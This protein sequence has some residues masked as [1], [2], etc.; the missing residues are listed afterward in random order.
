MPSQA[1][2]FLRSNET[3]SK[4]ADPFQ[5]Y[6]NQIYPKTVREVFEWA[7]WLWMRHGIYSQ[8]IKRSVRYFLNSI[9][10]YGEDVGLDTRKEYEQRLLQDQ[11][12]LDKIATI[13]DDYCAFGNSFT[14]VSLPITRNLICPVKGCGLSRS[15]D[16]LQEGTDYSWENFQFI[17]TCPQCGRR[18]TFL[19]HDTL[20]QR[21]DT[22]LQ[23]I[24]WQPQ[25]IDIDSCPLTGEARY[26]YRPSGDLKSKITSGDPLTLQTIPWEFVTAVK[27]NRR[28]EFNRD[29]F[30]H[31]K[32]NVCA[33][34]LE[35]M[36]G[37]GLPMFMSNFG[38]VVQLQILERFN[39]A[40]AHDYIVPLRLLTPALMAN[41]MDPLQTLG[42]NN[43]MGS[44][45]R[46]LQE[47]RQDP[48]S[49]HTMPAPLQYHMIGGEARQL[50]PVELID[51]TLDNLLTSMGIAT[52]F[53]RGTLQTGGPPIGLR[54]FEKTWIHHITNITTW[55]NWYLKKCNQFL[56]W[57]EVR[58]RLVMTSVAEDD[59]SKQ[60]KL[61]LAASQ[62]I[63][64]HT[65]LRAFNIDPDYERE[66]MKEEQRQMAEDMREEGA[67]ENKAQMLDEYMQMAPAGTIPPNAAQANMGLP[68][69]EAA[70]PMAGG[71][72]PAGGGMGSAP[73]GGTGGPTMDQMT[74]EAEQMAN[75]LLISPPNIRRT[76]LTNLKAQNPTL[77]ALVKQSLA[78]L[79]QGIKSDALAQTKYGGGGGM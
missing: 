77:H 72:M 53:Y 10:L 15:L 16:K 25:D 34:M 79:E 37:Y 24:R 46:M 42:M 71:V 61:N 48:T 43:F 7:E 33:H 3:L 9:E 6:S 8:A 13:G 76:E 5:T 73:I 58:G 51:R 36:R 2:N 23:V 4:F 69:G 17:G 39:E 64:N 55:L 60:V 78:D 52:E 40:I 70:P 56:L 20:E 38:Q 22:E 41:G 29:T 14:S 44:A 30:L 59:V 27:E 62:V 1:N 68:P 49:W 45:R 26:Y 31:L 18:S 12:I 54:M 19:R 35:R 28:I 63:S 21:E 47:H 50:V 65:A 67:R 57:K 66:R 74:A 32:T 11:G 75:Q